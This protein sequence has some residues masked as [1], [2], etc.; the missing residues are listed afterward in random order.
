MPRIYVDKLN[1]CPASVF[2]PATQH[3]PWRS[4]V[5]L[6]AVT[7][8]CSERLQTRVVKSYARRKSRCRSHLCDAAFTWNYRH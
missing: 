8:R 6:A 3:Q 5:L 2:S 7:A 1:G 4:H